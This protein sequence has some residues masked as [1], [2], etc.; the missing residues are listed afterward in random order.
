[1]VTYCHTLGLPRGILIYAND[2]PSTTGRNSKTSSSTHRLLPYMA[3]YMSLGNA[4][5]TSLGSSRVGFD[6]ET[7]S[8]GRC[9]RRRWASTQRATLCNPLDCIIILLYAT[10][11]VEGSVE[12]TIEFYETS[13]D[14]PVVEQELEAIEHTNPVLHDLLV[15]GL[16]KLRRREYHRP[17]LCESLAAVCSSCAWAK[18]YRPRRLVFS[19]GATHRGR[20]LLRKEVP[21]DAAERAGTGSQAND[22]T[23][24]SITHRSRT[25]RNEQTNFDRYLERKLQDA[26]FVPGLRP[27]SKP[28]ISPCSLL[29]CVKPAG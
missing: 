25:V 22:R 15:A 28:G 7:R 21:E 5:S 9:R 27:Q 19:G 1:M 14:Q 20:A 23:L 10:T 6:E 11:I 17:P 12:F 16:S 18:G 29:P 4:A 2:H 13:D 8:V 26:G 24:E 3:T